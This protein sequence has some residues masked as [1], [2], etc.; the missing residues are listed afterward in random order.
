ME[1]LY[2]KQYSD[3]ENGDIWLS[4]CQGIYEKQST[5]GNIVYPAVRHIGNINITQRR[6][7]K[8]AKHLKKIVNQEGDTIILNGYDNIYTR[9]NILFINLGYPQTL[10]YEITN[11][12]L[13]NSANLNIKTYK[14]DWDETREGVVN[15]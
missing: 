12:I 5:R 6:F 14:G 15:F 3:D 1:E 4:I 2:A 9:I 10:L 11:V 13:T 8:G 7:L